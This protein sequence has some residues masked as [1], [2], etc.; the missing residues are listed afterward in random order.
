VTIDAWDPKT[1]GAEISASLT[2]H[3]KLIFDYHVEDRRLMDE[4]L[5]SSPYQSLKSNRLFPAYQDFH[6]NTLAP[7]VA[8][9]RIRAWHYTR[10]TDEEADAMHQQLVPSSLEYL[11]YRLS[12][13]VEKN[14]LTQDDAETVFA[15]SPF[16][17]QSNRAGCLCVTIIPLSHCDGGVE[18]LLESWGGESAYFRLTDEGVA[19]A[20]K[21]LGT[22]RIIEIETAVTDKLNGY[23]VAKTVLAA[24]ARQLGAPVTLSGCDLFIEECIDTAEV[25][26]IHA[27]GDNFFEAIG[28]TYPEG[29]GALSKDDNESAT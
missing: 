27:K 18:L 1:F 28:T 8:R 26:R 20:L 6:E 13:L 22:P 23:K 5:N 11:R 14:L 10:L 16:H 3:S 15:Q 7:I 12:N 21:S 29:V 17:K 25:L 4:H 24:W 9:S 2:E 19:K